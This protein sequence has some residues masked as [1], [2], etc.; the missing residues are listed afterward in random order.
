MLFKWHGGML[1]RGCKLVVVY[2]INSNNFMPAIFGFGA[3]LMLVVVMS[4]VGSWQSDSQR[5]YCESIKF[6]S[7]VCHQDQILAQCFR[8][9]CTQA[10][11]SADYVCKSDIAQCGPIKGHSSVTFLN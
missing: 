2:S 6:P 11:S 9:W 10:S 7:S 8:E 5:A 3:G 4:V 1:C